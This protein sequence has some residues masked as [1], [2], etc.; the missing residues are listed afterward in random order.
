[1][2]KFFFWIFGA[3]AEYKRVEEKMKTYESKFI[4]NAARCNVYDAEIRLDTMDRLSD[5]FVKAVNTL[6]LDDYRAYLKL[7]EVFGTHYISSVVMGAKAIVRSEFDKE[8]WHKAS[9]DLSQVKIGASHA[10]WGSLSASVSITIYCW[11]L[12]LSLRPSSLTLV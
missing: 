8:A 4:L 7:I 10:F 11:S 2:G 3:S 6:P 9:K 5:S 1:M 12:Y